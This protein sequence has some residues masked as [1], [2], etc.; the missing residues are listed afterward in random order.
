M[1]SA[2]LLQPIPKELA[3]GASVLADGLYVAVGNSS[4]R[5]CGFM[6]G[7]EAFLPYLPT[8]PVGMTASI[9]DVTPRNRAV[10]PDMFADSL[11]HLPS[12]LVL[13]IKRNK[14]RSNG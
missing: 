7:F 3:K 12:S 9:V 10:L 11:F 13:R 4:Q 6:S 2:M 14:G 8:L 5:V 1:A